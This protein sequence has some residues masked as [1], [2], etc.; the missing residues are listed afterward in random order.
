ML[1]PE[2]LQHILSFL[3]DLDDIAKCHLVDNRHVHSDVLSCAAAGWLAC[4]L[5]IQH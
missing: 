5:L 4:W 2:I 3:E 1:P